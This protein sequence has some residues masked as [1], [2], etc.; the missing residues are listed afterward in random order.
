ME[1]IKRYQNRKLYSLKS[2]SYVT[3][4]YIADLVKSD[5]AF[6]V[7]DNKTKEDITN[8]TLKQSLLVLDLKTSDVL[9]LIRGN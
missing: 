8:K 6:T 3:L 2:S 1:Q 4:D 5:Q 9:S 7:F